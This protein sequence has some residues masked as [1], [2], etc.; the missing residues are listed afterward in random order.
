MGWFYNW[1]G[2]SYGIS[3]GDGV[4]TAFN[5]TATNPCVFARYYTVQEGGNGNWTPQSWLAGITGQ[6]Y[7]NTAPVISA[8]FTRFAM[9]NSEGNVFRDDWI[10][11]YVNAVNC[12]FWSAA[13]DGYYASE[14]FTNC[15]FFRSG[16]GL[17][18]NYAPANLSVQNCTFIGGSLIADHISGDVWPVTVVDSAFDGTTI[19]MNAYD[20]GT[21]GAYC[22]YNA[23]LTNADLTA[24]M[25][26][27]ELTNL[28]SYNWQSGW[29]GHYYLPPNSPLIDKGSTNANLLGLYHFT[30][31]TNQVKEANS[32]V[33]IG[34][35][36][37]ATDNN[38]NPLDSNSDGI[39]DYIEDANGNGLV[40]NGESPWMTQPPV[41]TLQPTN[42]SVIQG[43]NATFS[44]T[45]AGTALSY[46]WYFNSAVLT[47]A[48]NTTLTLN[49]VQPNNVGTY[50]VIVAN[51]TSS[52]TSSNAVLTVDMLPSAI[53]GLKLWLEANAG[54]TTN[55]TAKISTWADQSGSTNNATQSN[56]N[57][58]PLYVT[59]ALNGL[60]VVRFNPTNN[61]YFNF[62]LPNFMGGTTGAEAF[63]VLKV[64]ATVPGASVPVGVW[65][66]LQ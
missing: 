56:T 12:E 49:N 53:S 27:H 31:Q 30:T 66:L 34:Y 13:V 40:D 21:Q 61:Q 48:T 50:Y 20:F 11:L 19:Y 44:V 29:L 9:L 6:Y 26:G 58:Q 33:D 65:R 41:I 18:W 62:S 32:I 47:N 39:P 38:G 4:T 51:A 15:L 10:F 64:A 14:N 36:Y 1:S 52:V 22:D 28:I 8:S 54:I 24:V 25:G 35:H 37:V 42:Q 59:N 2:E 55:A 46:Q 60:P 16:A 23:F 45:A 63:V 43:S 3:L 17:W 57:Y 5:G 7:A